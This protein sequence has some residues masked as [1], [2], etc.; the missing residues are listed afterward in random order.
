MNFR[1]SWKTHLS[2]FCDFYLALALMIFTIVV[3]YPGYMSPDSVAMLQMARTGVT[4]NVYSPLMSYVWRIT[5][6]LIPG[7]GG[8]L[9]FQAFVY[10]LSLALI[11]FC[12]GSSRMLG[13]LFICT[14]LWIPT[15]ALLGTIW[16]D[17]GMQGF[18]LMAVAL[19]LFGRRL[20]RSWPLVLAV[21]SLF[22]AC[23]YRQNGILAVLPL[24]IIVLYYSSR[25]ER[26]AKPWSE[27][28]LAPAFY[29]GV[30]LAILGAFLGGL[31]L[32]NSYRIQ[33]G[34]LWSA[35]MVHDLAAISVFQNVNY[36]PAY[37]NPGNA[38]TVEDLKHMY[39]PLHANSLF[40]PE[41]RKFLEMPDPSPDKVVRY[42]LTDEEARDLQFYW[43]T[44]VLDHFGSYLRH[45]LLM[46]QRLLVLR[47]HQPWEPYVTD[48]YTN[49]FGLTFHRTRLNAWV[50]KLTQYAA[51]STRLY[52]AW[53]YYAVVTVC[54][55]VSFFWRFEHA[56]LVQCLGASV[57]LYFLSIFMFGMS[58]DFRYNI[59]ALTCAPLCIFLLLCGRAGASPAQAASETD[60]GFAQSQ[61]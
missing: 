22:F 11:A 51:F 17:V 52:S 7:P 48:I 18:L 29:T 41:S 37:V 55:F 47:S 13:I 12:A 57:W 36:L 61:P 45:R 44:T 15:F 26:R 49:P 31:W 23:G 21:M 42:N 27:N 8:M 35:A 24:L 2:T 14:G 59:W 32:L 16:K 60:N 58:G 34:K 9:I 54:V 6:L 46:A 4:S 20:G 43:L 10:W 28:D 53:M 19:S 56:L 3:Y 30:A 39:S 33:D 38:L 5:D 25:Q 1:T 50:T 40:N